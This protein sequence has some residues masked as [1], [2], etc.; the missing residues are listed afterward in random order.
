MDFFITDNTL[1]IAVRRARPPSL[2]GREVA[3]M[4]QTSDDAAHP[5]RIALAGAS[6]EARNALASRL[7]RHA[8]RV[9]VLHDDDDALDVVLVDPYA[10]GSGFDA[11]AFDADVLEGH[12]VVIF[13]PGAEVDHLT[14][15]MAAAALGGQLRG[16][17]SADLGARSLVGALELVRAG[18]IVLHGVVRPLTA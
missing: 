18:T 7:R 8:G 3:R 17:L 2:S 5:I 16:W 11:E 9:S 1:G 4:P 10:A 12:Q 6:D 14:F 13:T 15:A